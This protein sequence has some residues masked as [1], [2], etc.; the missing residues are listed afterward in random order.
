MLTD[1]ELQHGYWGSRRLARQL[2]TSFI[3]EPEDVGDL[4]EIC[5]SKSQPPLSPTRERQRMERWCQA[6]PSLGLKTLIVQCRVN[7]TLWDAITRIPSLEALDATDSALSSLDGI[8]RLTQLKALEFGSR[9][10]ITDLSPLR[11]L[12]HL[13]H[14]RLFRMRAS[15]DL[16]FVRGMTSLE[17]FGFLFNSIDKTHTID[18]LEPLSTLSALQLLWLDVKVRRDGLQPLMGLRQLATLSV[19]FTYPASEFAAIRKALPSLKY[20]APFEEETIQRYCPP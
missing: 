17:E 19:S 1:I 12:K 15:T 5:L 7:D 2:P 16:E 18:S 8:D 20:G 10:A 11:R 4:T 9:S 13:R 6:L 14:L 3:A